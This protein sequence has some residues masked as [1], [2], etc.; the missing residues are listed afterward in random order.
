M[1]IN[2]K[3]RLAILLSCL[4]S[5]ALG[6]GTS[7]YLRTLERLRH[8]AESTFRS[9]SELIS[10]FVA[11]HRDQVAVMRN[12][13]LEHYTEPG[14]NAAAL[15]LQQYPEEN[16]WRLTPDGP[17]PAGTLSGSGKQP[18][19][20][21]QQEI[22]AAIGM[23]G[24]L[25]PALEYNQEVAWLYYL[26]ANNFIYIAPRAPFE[27]FHFQ[28][29]LYQRDYWRHASPPA[30]PQRRLILEG[31]FQDMGGKGWVLSFTEPVYAGDSFLGVVA[32]DLRIN[33]LQQ[34]TGVGSAI[35]ETMMIS[36]DH[37]LIARQGAFFPGAE[38]NPPLSDSPSD[39]RT[40]D[41]GDHWLSSP[42]VP[43]EL[44]VVHQIKGH[45]LLWAA[46]RESAPTW[47]VIVLVGL[48]GVLS[49]RLIGAL[50][51]LARMVHTDPLTLLLNR[52][53][54]FD[55]AE[56]LLALAQRKQLP[57]AVLIMDIDH[58]KTINDNYGHD[59]G[60]SVLKQLGGYVLKARRP[61]DL[62]CRWGGEEFV[63]VLLLEQAE[64]ALAVAERMRQEVQRTR[65]PPNDLPITLSGG[66]VLLH[67][68][69]TLEQAIKRADL[70]LYAAKHNG[71]NHIRQTP[72]G[73]DAT[74]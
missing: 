20:G 19:T 14:H 38:L 1:L 7:V 12:L 61:F 44:W 54:L 71:R 74:A 33:T 26:S 66:L 57:L 39:W 21:Q 51:Q 18:T 30:N 34:L 32:L 37:N 72:D 46:A 4:T 25:R 63:L 42:V 35:G 64:Q 27:Q 15:T 56:S 5:L 29:A 40:D 68:D 36:E 55:R 47:L 41:A 10:T 67:E 48:L 16:V 43:D 8:E 3:K 28:P 2:S 49:W 50:A 9:R 53:G 22:T 59:A 6:I 13:L 60:D 73:A 70:L 58:F 31:P 69:E 65:I 62:V 52:R 45:E 23:D 17:S 11:L 24:Q